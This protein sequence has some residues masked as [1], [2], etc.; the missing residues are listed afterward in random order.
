MCK[1][2]EKARRGCQITWR[3]TSVLGREGTGANCCLS[4]P[5]GLSF[6]NLT[7]RPLP[8]TGIKTFSPSVTPHINFV[9]VPEVGVE[10]GESWVK[11]QPGLHR[12]FETN[13]GCIEDA[14]LERRKKRGILITC[15]FNKTWVLFQSKILHTQ[16]KP[17]L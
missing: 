8:N 15:E 9:C 3:R 17:L 11:G 10:V 6:L 14:L 4:D 16:T 12:E 1:V 5:L 13:Q 7:L 2:P